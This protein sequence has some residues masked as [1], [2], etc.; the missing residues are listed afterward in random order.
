MRPCTYLRPGPW[1]ADL[2]NLAARSVPDGRIAAEL[3]RR[4]APLR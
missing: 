1:L 2:Y 3:S 4:H